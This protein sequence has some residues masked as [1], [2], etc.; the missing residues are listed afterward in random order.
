MCTREALSGSGRGGRRRVCG[1]AMGASIW[2]GCVVGI[3]TLHAGTR[4]DCGVCPE[5]THEIKSHM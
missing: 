2:T 4:S 3:E 1:S 5:N